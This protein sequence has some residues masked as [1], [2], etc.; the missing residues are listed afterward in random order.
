[1]SDNIEDLD[2]SA[3]V[4]GMDG[5]RVRGIIALVALRIPPIIDPPIAFAHR[6]ARALA[7]DNTIDAFRLGLEMGATGLESDVWVT[8]D[9]VPVLDHD[10]V[11]RRRLQKT[12]IAKVSR[13]TLPEHIPTL[14][15]LYE[16]CGTGWHLSLDVKD[17]QAAMPVLATMVD[18][19]ERFGVDLLP[20]VWMCH[21]YWETLA[22]WKQRHPTARFVDSTRL[23]RLKDGPE[24]HAS[25]LADAGIDAI[26]MHHSD[27]NG[28]LVT[29]FHRFD[30]AC[31][32]W[33][34]Q[35]D[36]VL[37]ETFDFGIDG[38][39]SDHV[40]RM[41]AAHAAAY[42]TAGHDRLGGSDSD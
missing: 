39:Y 25:R 10:G 11:V 18:L 4:V 15:E 14:T 30:T 19:S 40:D 1:M 29:L 22:G 27:W 41:M 28:G 42:G 37:A 16:E 7:R 8:S 9:G 34:A 32:A 20:T 5:A 36:R 31:F 13:D 3:H 24:R 12:P 38:I 6:G 17:P 23:N 33:D 21:P 35:Y 2:H 26:N